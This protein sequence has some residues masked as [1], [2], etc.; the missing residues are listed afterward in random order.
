MRLLGFCSLI[1][2]GLLVTPTFA[3]SQPSQSASHPAIVD[4]PNYDQL[5]AEMYK[6]FYASLGIKEVPQVEDD[7]QSPIAKE[8][9]QAEAEACYL[10]AAGLWS[11]CLVQTNGDFEYCNNFLFG[12]QL[13][14]DGLAAGGVTDGIPADTA[15][16]AV[17]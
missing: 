2:V 15:P 3:Q 9:M 8:Q 5:A 1:F 12:I 4:T 7:S 6:R 10:S 13:V 17:E 11:W 14:C 16:A